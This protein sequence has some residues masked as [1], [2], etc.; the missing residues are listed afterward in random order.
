V[1]ITKETTIEFKINDTQ[2]SYLKKIIKE[3]YESNS[4]DS[5]N[6]EEFLKLTVFIV[7]Y[8]YDKNKQSLK[9]FYKKNKEGYKNNKNKTSS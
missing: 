1:D 4:I 7:L 5:E 9:E 3:L 6:M 2:K 8:E